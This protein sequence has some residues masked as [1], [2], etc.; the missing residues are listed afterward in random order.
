MA[1]ARKRTYHAGEVQAFTVNSSLNAVPLYR[2]FA[3]QPANEAARV[4]RARLCR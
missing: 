3:F 1:E 2:L 4:A